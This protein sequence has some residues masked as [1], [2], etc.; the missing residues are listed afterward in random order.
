MIDLLT[1]EKRIAEF[2]CA[3]LYYVIIKLRSGHVQLASLGIRGALCLYLEPLQHCSC[4]NI[5][6][7][8]LR[9]DLN[10]VFIVTRGVSLADKRCPLS[11]LD[12][13]TLYRG[14]MI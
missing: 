13:L 7:R 2:T 9:E 11:S 12:E 5:V 1:G 6:P 4:S 3:R 8:G 10:C 14:H